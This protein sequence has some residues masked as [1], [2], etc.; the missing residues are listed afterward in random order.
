MARVAPGSL[1]QTEESYYRAIRAAKLTDTSMNASDDIVL[2]YSN[3]AFQNWVKRLDIYD[4][5]KR[6]ANFYVDETIV[7]EFTNYRNAVAAKLPKHAKY[8]G[9]KLSGQLQNIG[10]CQDGSKVGKMNEADSLYVLDADISVVKTNTG[11]AY[12]IF[13][14]QKNQNCEITPR[15]MRDQFAKGYEEVISNAPLPN[16]LRHAGYKSPPGYS[17]L[18]YN[19]PAATSQ[20]LTE[21]NSPLT[22]DM[23]PTFCLAK[24]HI[25]YQEV[26]NIIQPALEAN[27]E[28][29][30]GDM[31]IHLIP[32]AN[33]DIW[34]LSTAQLEADLLRELIP[35]LAPMRQALSA[36]KALASEVK[37]WN[38]KNL[39]LPVCSAGGL[40]IMGELEAYL[41]RGDKNL[42]ERLNQ[43][44]RYAHI[45]IPP[46]ERSQ[47]HEDE[48]PHVSINTA[49]IKHILLAEALKNPAAFAGKEDKE[50]VRELMILVFNTLGDPTQFSSPHAFLKGTSIPHVSV[51]SSQAENKMALA[52]SIKE[53]CRFLVSGA[54][55]KVSQICDVFFIKP[56][57]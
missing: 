43:K 8:D 17:G 57:S 22:W 30:F 44:L 15:S 53:Q 7:M 47:Y 32:D 12:R 2:P 5:D 27:P 36:S 31:R 42:E 16:C 51:L 20:F 46:A 45:W 6:K 3:D 56:A 48:K 23:T 25:T 37:I 1:V 38:V 11:G 50:L 10:S 34:R 26:R 55:T 39:T 19:G 9:I 28:T 54:M 35:P 52:L 49:A 29:M 33:D 40:G 13:W 41:Q 21:D 18:R 14:E 24:G 4:L